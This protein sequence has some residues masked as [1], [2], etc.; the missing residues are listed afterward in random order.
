VVETHRRRAT[1]PI[2]SDRS[3][4][5]CDAS[6]TG[7]VSSLAVHVLVGSSSRPRTAGAVAL[8]DEFGNHRAS[9]VVGGVW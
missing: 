1:M 7:R 5:T 8:A 4:A 2:G 6:A 9:A 3:D